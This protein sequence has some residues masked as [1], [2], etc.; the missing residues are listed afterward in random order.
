[1]EKTNYDFEQIRMTTPQAAKYL[2]L[3]PKTLAMWRNQGKLLRFIKLGSRVFY[4]KH[5]LDDFISQNSGFT[6]TAQAQVF[7]KMKEAKNVGIN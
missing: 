2:G 4:T 7:I 3:R 5:D 6:S 1:M